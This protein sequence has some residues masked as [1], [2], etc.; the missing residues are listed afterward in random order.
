MTSLSVAAS[1]EPNFM[2]EPLPNARS[3]WPR[4]ASKAFCLSMVSLSNRRNAGCDIVLP[5]LFHRVR[6]VAIDPVEERQCI[7]FVHCG[8]FFF[9]SGL[10]KQKSHT[11]SY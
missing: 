2:I 11:Q 4:A 8:K 7:W 10:T 9:C 5:F 6:A 1:R 3:I